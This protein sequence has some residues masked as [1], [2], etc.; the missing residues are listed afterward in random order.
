M[1]TAQ[2]AWVWQRT[3]TGK[4][5]RAPRHLV[6]DTGGGVFVS[7]CG[8]EGVAAMWRDPC[9]AK[10]CGKCYQTPEGRS[11]CDEELQRL[12]PEA[13]LARPRPR[14]RGMMTAQS[15]TSVFRVVRIN[16]R[17]DW[18]PEHFNFGSTEQLPFGFY[19]HKYEI[20]LYVHIQPP[21]QEVEE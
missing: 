1:M 2:S 19:L 15:A 14:R 17:F 18:T 9:G 4:A 3:A 10:V 16:R 13:P 20:P 5:G 11:A 6:R 12:F 8:L 21:E 7:A